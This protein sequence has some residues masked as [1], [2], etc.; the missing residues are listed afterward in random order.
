MDLTALLPSL[1]LPFE[2][3]VRRLAG[4]GFPQVDVLGLPERPSIHYDA[5]AETGLRV[6]CSSIGKNLANACTLD[7]ADVG[8]R[9][10]ALEETRRHI[11]DA[12][13]L[14]ATHC[15]LVP[16]L[17]DS[18]DGL[19]RFADACVLLADYAAER[20]IR[21]CVEH[22]PGRALP[23][24]AGTLDWLERVGHAN[25]FLLLDVGHCLISGE[26]PAVAATRAGP[27]LGYVHL[28]DNDG[29]RD[30]H[31]PLFTGRLTE[32][33]LRTFL[34]TLPRIG[35]D[36]PLCLELNPENADPV[37]ALS[38]GRDWLLKRQAAAV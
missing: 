29:V 24:V 33:T 21:L 16:G 34:E 38:D 27:R 1:P 31:W 15:Y 30:V 23:T 26:D 4:L 19:A 14:G 11:L 28:D 7:M 35:Y 36:G 37:A 5:L 20:M 8:C 12:A 9:R 2:E 18:A 10:A 13:R 25:L 6:R 22:I 3:A 17:D 32:T